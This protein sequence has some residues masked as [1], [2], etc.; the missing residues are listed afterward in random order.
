MPLFRELKSLGILSSG[1]IR[2]NRLLGCQLRSEKELK[3]EGRGSYD[4]KIAEE[5]DVVI[6]RWHD[7]G[8][9]N[10]ISTVVGLGNITKV[11]RWSEA[12]KKHVDI[13][14]PQ[15][16]AE[17]NRFMGGVDKLDFLISLYPLQAKTKKWPVRVISHFVSFAV[18]NSWLEYI[19]DANAEGLRKKEVKDVM[20]FQSDIA[21]SLIASNRALPNRR[22]RPSVSSPKP[23]PKSHVGVPMPTNSTRF[24]GNNH[25]PLHMNANFPQRC[26]NTGCVSKSHVCCRK[27][28]VFLCLSAAKDCYYEFHTKM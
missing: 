9:V 28:G 16:I 24:D 8:P 17:Y 13:D 23:V 22:G 10:M 18:C 25:W 27:C 7:N 2:A 12:A 3:K 19:R 15:V 6:V 1:T 21:R 26:R 4:S 11:N 14:C 5:E 20:A